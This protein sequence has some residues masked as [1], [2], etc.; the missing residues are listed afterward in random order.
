MFGTL[1]GLLK[2]TICSNCSETQIDEDVL[3]S[4]HL[5]KEDIW[6]KENIIKLS[7]QVPPAT[8]IQKKIVINLIFV[9]IQHS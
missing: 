2:K 9:Y 8:K 6:S 5:S 4:I 7:S 1:V 3:K